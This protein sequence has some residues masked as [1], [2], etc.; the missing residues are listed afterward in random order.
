MFVRPGKQINRNI[1]PT[2][3]VAFSAPPASLQGAAQPSFKFTSTD[4]WAQDINV[5]VAFRF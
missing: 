2:Q 5:G 1:N 4:F 3:G